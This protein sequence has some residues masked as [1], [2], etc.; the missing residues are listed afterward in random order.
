VVDEVEQALVS[1]V[2]VLE[3]EH[4][5]PPLREL[6]QEEPPRGEG[7]A[8]AVAARLRFAADADER[9]QVAFYPASLTLLRD[10]VANGPA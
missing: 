1:P 4:E 2:Q 9:A 8:P 7:L 3:D 5:R 6:L 10:E